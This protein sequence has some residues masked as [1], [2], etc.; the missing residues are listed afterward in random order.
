MDIIS[1]LIDS[2]LEK[3]M[4]THTSS[5]L[6]NS[7][8][9][10]VWQAAVHGATKS[11][12]Q[13][14]DWAPLTAGKKKKYAKGQMVKALFLIAEWMLIEMAKLGCVIKTSCTSRVY[15]VVDFDPR[16]ST[17]VFHFGMVSRDFLGVAR[18][19]IKGLFL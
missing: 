9:R 11:L 18:R 3:E 14:S 13:L 17:S 8:D 6:E 16:L 7:M 19:Q 2:S 15:Q 12:T 4:A 10:E 1:G 5:C